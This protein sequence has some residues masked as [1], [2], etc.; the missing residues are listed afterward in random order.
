MAIDAGDFQRLT[1]DARVNDLALWLRAGAD[2]AAVQAAHRARCAGPDAA[3][4]EFASARRD[5]RRS[6]CASSTAASP[7]PTGCRRWPSRSACSASRRASRRRCWRGA[8]VRPARAPGPDAA[9]GAR[10]GGRRRRGLDGWPAR[11]PGW[12]WAWR[13]AWCWCTWSTR[14]AFTGPWTCCCPGAAW[15][16]CARRWWLAGTVTAW[17]A[18]RAAAPGRTRCWR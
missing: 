1:G 13:S 7:S 9:A 14:R 12:R 4:L 6:R 11:W 2:A 16:C 15:R 5:P 17:L 8:R 3:L 18:G 10:R